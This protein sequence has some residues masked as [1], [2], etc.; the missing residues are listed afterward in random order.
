MDREG[1]ELP[2][3]KVCV[4]LIHSFNHSFIHQIFTANLLPASHYYLCWRSSNEQHRKGPCFHGVYVLDGETD[5][6][7]GKV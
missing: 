5:D 6:K 4:L 3:T 7:D 2:A 1:E